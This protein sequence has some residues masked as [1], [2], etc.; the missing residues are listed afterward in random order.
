MIYTYNNI[1]KIY[2][3]SDI[4][5]ITNLVKENGLNLKYINGP[6]LS[7]SMVAL[8]Q[9]GMALEF[10]KDQD[11]MKCCTAVKQNGL[12]LKFV[13]NQDEIICMLAVKQNGLA[14]KYV[15]EKTIQI[16]KEAIKQNILADKYINDYIRMEIF[17]D[18]R[19]LP[20]ILSE[21]L[22]IDNNIRIS[23]Y[24]LISKMAYNFNKNGLTVTD[25]FILDNYTAN[26]LKK[27]VGRKI[28]NNQL[29][30]FIDEFFKDKIDFELDYY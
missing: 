27:Q 9:N 28:C 12:A 5:F 10:I 8:N 19:K 1:I 23:K 17:M 21:Y 18:Y 22:E 30:L 25:G 15:K 29:E 24:D 13:Q 26:K 20:L 14:L 11:R 4:T 2:M 6:S 3:I 16:C 7:L